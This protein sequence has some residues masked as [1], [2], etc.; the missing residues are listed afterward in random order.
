MIGWDPS[1]EV[2]SE[3]DRETVRE[4]IDPCWLRTRL[5]ISILGTGQRVNIARTSKKLGINRR[6][7][8]QLVSEVRAQMRAATG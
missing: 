4:L 2:A 1:W 5:L 7:A 3:A 8:T 6:R